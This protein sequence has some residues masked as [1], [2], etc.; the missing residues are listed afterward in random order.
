LQFMAVLGEDH[1]YALTILTFI[2]Y[3]KMG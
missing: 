3:G 2:F 1:M